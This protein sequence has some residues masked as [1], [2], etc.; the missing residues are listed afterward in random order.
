M[1][2]PCFVAVSQSEGR[3]LR[4][5]IHFLREDIGFFRIK[6]DAFMTYTIKEVTASLYNVIPIRVTQNEGK[7]KCLFFIFIVLPVGVIVQAF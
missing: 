1:L 5:S 4:Y 3:L 7:R 6:A 2:I